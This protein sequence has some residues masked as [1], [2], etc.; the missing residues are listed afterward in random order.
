MAVCSAKNIHLSKNNT[1]GKKG[2]FYVLK[3]ENLY[4]IDKV[5]KSM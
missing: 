3:F 2:Q 4:K 1:R 5:L